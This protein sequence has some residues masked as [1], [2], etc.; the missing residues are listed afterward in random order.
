MRQFAT[1]VSLMA[2]LAGAPAAALAQPN[3]PDQNMI[4]G[5]SSMPNPD[6]MPG[7]SMG[8]QNMGGQYGGQNMGQHGGQN[9]GGGQYGSQN[10]GGQY[11]QGGMSGPYEGPGGGG[12]PMVGPNGGP[13]MGPQGMPGQYGGGRYGAPRRAYNQQ[14]RNFVEQ[15][16]SAGLA[17]VEAGNLAIK[18]AE[19]PA[20]SLFGR[21]MVT[22]HTQMGDLLSHIAEHSGINVPTRVDDKDRQT[23]DDL[24]KHTGGE[25]D[26]HYVNDQIDAHR[27]AIELFKQ[28]AQS[29][30]N[31]GLR[32]FAHHSQDM[33]TQHLAGAQ[34]LKSSPESSSAR[35]AHVSSPGTAPMED[36]KKASPGLQAGTS[37]ALRHNLN[38]TGANR[39]E[40]EGK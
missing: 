12:M 18:R 4:P 39:L 32:W 21:W 2:L 27:K 5:P 13:M 9:M 26:L 10:M 23:L 33:L 28:E 3:G 1:T 20:V 29:G 15:A 40:K 35:A 31:P 25:F 16:T 6:M 24:R 17:E 7:Q 14:D 34:A 37:P 22:D 36:A 11:R 8:G 30:Q 19:S 38:E